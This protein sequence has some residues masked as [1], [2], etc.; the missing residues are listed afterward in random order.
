MTAGTFFTFLLAKGDQYGSNL[1]SAVSRTDFPSLVSAF[2]VSL[3]VDL[4]A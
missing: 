4:D 2:P 3:A 1:H